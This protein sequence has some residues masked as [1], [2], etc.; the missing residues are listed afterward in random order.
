MKRKNFNAVLITLVVVALNT[1]I[2]IFPSVSL[3]AAKSGLLLWASSVLPGILPFVIGVNVLVAL[4]AINFVG[5]FLSPVMR[6]VFK[7]PGRAAFAMVMGMVS[8]YPVGS[9]IV[10]EMRTRGVLSKS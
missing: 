9:K 6:K 3:E 4:G 2:I 5:F 1:L 8:G 7:L 10:S